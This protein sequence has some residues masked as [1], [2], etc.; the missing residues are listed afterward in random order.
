MV[1][2]INVQFKKNCARDGRCN[3][4]RS[5]TRSDRTTPSRN[6]W[7]KKRPNKKA[8]QNDWF[9]PKKK[10]RMFPNRAV[11]PDRSAADN[12]SNPNDPW[13]AIILPAFMSIDTAPAI[14]W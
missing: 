3:M 9:T 11:K 2:E 7:T 13:K 5:N 10:D 8:K 1:F 4:A 6:N 14:A 12:A